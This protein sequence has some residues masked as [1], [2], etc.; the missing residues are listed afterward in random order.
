MLN[1]F[2]GMVFE[3]PT[4]KRW[5][6][7][8]SMLVSILIVVISVFGIAIAGIIIIPKLPIYNSMIDAR[9]LSVSNSELPVVEVVAP[10]MTIDWQAEQKTNTPD[11]LTPNDD[12]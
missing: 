8:V 9:M 4:R 12:S 11:G 1:F 2:R 10:D 6:Y 5:Q 7:T 3:D